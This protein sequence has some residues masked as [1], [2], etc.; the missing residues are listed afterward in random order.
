VERARLIRTIW[1]LGVLLVAS[2]VL[3][4]APWIEGEARVSPLPGGRN[5]LVVDGWAVASCG[6]VDLTFTV[7]GRTI[8]AGNPYLRWPGLPERLRALP[9]AEYAG[10]STPF[11]SGSLAPGAHEAIVAARACGVEKVLCRVPF[12]VAPRTSAW[13][14]GPILLLLLV[15]APLAL[16][17]LVARPEPVSFRR[18]WV[19]HA[20]GVS[21]LLGV[22][23][24]LAGPHVGAIESPLL[25]GPFAALL[26]WDAGW[27]L[28]IARDGYTTPRSFAYFP[29]F[30]LVLRALLR[31]PVPIRPAGALLNGLFF[32]LSMACLRR[33]YPGRDHAILLLAFLPFSFFFGAVYTE[34]MFV[35]LTA[36]ALLAVRE[37][38]GVTAAGLGALAALT[39]VTGIAAG[40]FAL[41][42]L[43][44]RKWRTAALVAAGPPAGLVVWML[45]LRR[46]TGDAFRFLHAQ[47]SFGRPSSF[48][49]ALLLDRLVESVRRGSA[50]GLWEVGLLSAV[51]VGAGGLLRRRRWAEGLFSAAVVLMP[52]Y[53]H[54]TASLNR[55][56]LAA[57][58][59]LIFLFERVS[60]RALPLV[61]VAEAALLVLWGSRFG[62]FVFTG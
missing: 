40:L 19:P 5:T 43:A 10:F 47:E 24:I 7:D 6:T 54:S 61:L 1:I 50:L 14:A 2:P 41:A 34:A 4:Q 32:A 25:P 60:P 35:F 21:W 44:A 23:A 52:L 20:L 16:G 27:Y 59:A 48:D 8:I 49:P 29:A 57:F 33:L 36:A 37:N 17:S 42:P 15:A 58:P 28:G 30:P 3:A 62:R 53:T 56:A 13:I 38:R 46:R 11:D 51:L 18:P 26:N 9:S 31:L 55:Y 39:R 22:L 45:W 12:A